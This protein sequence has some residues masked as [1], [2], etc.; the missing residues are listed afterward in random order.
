MRSLKNPDDIEK[1][2]AMLFEISEA[3]SFVPFKTH[4]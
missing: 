4:A 1:I 2:E 3:F